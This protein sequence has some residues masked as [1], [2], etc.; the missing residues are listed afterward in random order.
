MSLFRR[1]QRELVEPRP[2]LEVFRAAADNAL[3]RDHSQ[4]CCCQPDLYVIGWVKAPDGDWHSLVRVAH[5]EW[6][7]L[8]RCMEVPAGPEVMEFVRPGEGR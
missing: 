3:A 1:K 2:D 4:G 8:M 6:C 5:D 7:P